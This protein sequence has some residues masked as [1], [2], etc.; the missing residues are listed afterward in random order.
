MAR[1]S[2]GW[3][4]NGPE[5]EVNHYVDITGTF[6]RKVAAVTP[7]LGARGNPPCGPRT[8]RRQVRQP[9]QRVRRQLQPGRGQAPSPLMRRRPSPT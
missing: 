7:A 9:K 6:D 4:I 1:R 3:L 8:R 5:R 2:R